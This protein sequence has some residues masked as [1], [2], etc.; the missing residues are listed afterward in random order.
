M[1][2]SALHCYLYSGLKIDKISKT[3]IAGLGGLLEFI[4]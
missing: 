2:L 1:P 3:S 4:N